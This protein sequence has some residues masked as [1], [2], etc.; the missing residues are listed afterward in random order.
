MLGLE[1]L[2][3]PRLR[4]ERRGFEASDLD[5]AWLVVQ[6]TLDAELARR[7]GDLCQAR[8]IFFCAVD[9]PQHS[10]YAHLAVVREGSLTL[11][12]TRPERTMLT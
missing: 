6:V 1:S 12:I 9:Q 2:A 10:S 3:S 5:D 7:L 8:R 4:V 11:A